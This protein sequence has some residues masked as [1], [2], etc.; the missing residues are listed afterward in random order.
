MKILYIADI[1]NWVFDKTA[2]VLQKYGKHNY[3]IRYRGVKYKKAFINPKDFDLIVYSTDVRPDYIMKYRPPRKKTVI[4]IRSDV[5]KL[6]AKGRNVFYKDKRIAKEH[7]AAFMISNPYLL[8][9]FE[10]I[11]DIPCYYA[12]GGVDTEVFKKD[13]PDMYWELPIVGWAGSLKYHGRKLRGLDLVLD[14]CNYAGYTFCPAI[15][16][17]TYRTIDEMV[18]YYNK[19]ISLYIDASS[20]AGRQNGLLEAGA[21]GLPLMCTEVGIGKELIDNKCAIKIERD[22][23]SIVDGLR[24]AWGHRIK[25]GQNVEKYVRENWS[26]EEHVKKWEKIFEGI[27]W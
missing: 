14:A 4:L 8:E 17:N 25:L 3:T 2:R 18:D 26:W 21:C 11:H 6:C 27:R 7:C 24:N 1:K 22:P 16:E 10:K 19:E 13:H 5:F 15:K 23:N 9:K 12:P 20:T